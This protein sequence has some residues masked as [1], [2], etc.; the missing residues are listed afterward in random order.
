MKNLNKDIIK[1]VEA[2]QFTNEILNDPLRLAY[3]TALKGYKEYLSTNNLEG[4]V[5]KY[6]KILL[7]I[8]KTDAHVCHLLFTELNLKN[9]IFVGTAIKTKYTH[10]KYGTNTSET[11]RTVYQKRDKDPSRGFNT[12][13]IS[14]LSCFLYEEISKFFPTDIMI[15]Y[16]TS[17][18][19]EVIKLLDLKLDKFNYTL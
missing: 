11:S 18:L 12:L 4:A 10:W 16:K 8:M 15:N 13:E 14:D 19:K 6:S 9:E 7:K 2:K 17:N 5:T 1:K 3:Y